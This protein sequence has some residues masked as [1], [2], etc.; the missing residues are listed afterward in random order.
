MQFFDT[1]LT[2]YGWEGA[3]LAGALLVMLG[4]QLYYYIF[5]YGRIPG[6]KNNRRAVVLDAEPPVSVVI[7]MF[8]EDYA[9]IEER[10][11]LILAQNYPDFEVVIVYVGQDSDFYED[12]V[13]LKMSFPQITTTKIH[14]DPR[15][16]IS[17]KMALNV[18]I[19]SA[20]N[21]WLVFSSTDACPQ[22]DRWLSLMAKGFMRGEIVVGY[23][24][25]ERKKGFAN[26][27]MRTW[28][29]MHSVDWIARAVQHRPYRGTLH[30]F[31]FTKRLY[32]GANGFSHLNMNIGE[33]DLFMQKVM[34]RDNVSVILSPRASLREKTWG[35]MGWWM[36]QLHYYGSAF[37]YY[38][39]P[40]K[41]F[42]QWELGS[43][44][45][46]FAAVICALAVMPLEYK[47]GALALLLVRYVFVVVQVRRI[48]C[49]LGEG[50]IAGRYFIYDLLSPLW[51]LV[52]GA[53]LL[54]KDERVWR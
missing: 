19:K 52:L 23:C 25:L 30:N 42:I 38:P 11:P 9:F 17:R 20:H 46:F 5:V 31:G 22:T 24:G 8:S 26:F 35:G 6:Y 10:L 2:C 48:A 51:A 43:R 33:D 37:R 7:P 12:L 18:G 28:R 36:N 4:V 15:F 34:T 3:A 47:L 13:R 53:R 54:R 41:N 27:M 29:M 32:F 14:L 1:F 16:P 44:S 40:V 49:R 39:Q 21:E 50:G 45:L